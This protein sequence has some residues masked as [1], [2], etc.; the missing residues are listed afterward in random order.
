MSFKEIVDKYESTPT[1]HLKQDTSFATYQDMIDC[2]CVI[3]N[4]DYESH[5]DSD[6]SDLDE[7]KS[8]LFADIANEDVDMDD[9]IDTINIIDELFKYCKK[10]SASNK[11]LKNEIKEIKEYLQMNK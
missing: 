7:I 8:N 11:K 6:S 3:E 10:L 4:Y 9:D 5:S 1:V 2:Q